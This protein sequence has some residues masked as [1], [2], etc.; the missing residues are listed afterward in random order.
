MKIAAFA[1]EIDRAMDI[2]SDEGIRAKKLPVSAAFH[3]ALV[4]EADT[5][6]G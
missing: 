3:S 6:S 2:L 5:I 1:D 4:A